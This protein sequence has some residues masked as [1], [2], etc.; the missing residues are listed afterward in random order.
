[1][2]DFFKY[3]LATISGII[4]TFIILFF[5]A[6][7]IMVSVLS[8][9]KDEVS[10]I[11]ANTVLQ[12]NLN[13]PVTDRASEDITPLLMGD[14]IMPVGLTDILENID[15]AATD[16]NISGILL[17]ISSIGSGAATTTEIR[18]ALENFKASGKF[19]YAYSEVY[20]QKAYY[21]ATVADK[22][23]LNPAGMV[24]F[25]GL[26]AQLMFYKNMLEKVDVEVQ[27]IR[28][29]GNK[30]KSAVEPFIRDDMSEANR[31][32]TK[33]YITAVWDSF[34]EKISVDRNIPVATLNRYADNLT[35]LDA[36][37]ALEANLV[38]ELTYLD[39]LYDYIDE[40]CGNTPDGKIKTIS[41]HKYKSVKSEIEKPFTKDKIAVIYATGNIV[42]GKGDEKSVGSINFAKA[43]RKARLDNNI[44]SVV[45]RV[46]SPGGSIIASDVILRELRLLKEV[47][48]VVASY[49]DVAASGGYYISCFADKIVA[50]PN[51]ITGSIGVFG[52]FPNLEGLLI[53]KAGITLDH[54]GTNENA[55]FPNVFK[56]LNSFEKNELKRSVTDGYM[57]FTTLVAEGRGMEREDVDNIGQGRVWAGVDA[58]TIGLVDEFGGLTRSI[59]IAAELASLDNYRIRQLPDLKDP[60]QQILD[61]VSGNP[62]ETRLQN[63]MGPYYS[64]YNNIR[65]MNQMTGIQARLP[66]EIDIY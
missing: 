51:T 57:K 40:A 48:P 58:I 12:I 42:D 8:F 38:D 62:T 2:R 15:K 34:I 33:R 14:F 1:M 24:E 49:G 13:Y 63:I 18:N 35:G 54:V 27:V 50:M 39:Q 60:I 20:T 19:I 65:N 41:L 6:S 32:Q 11:D 30:Y 9:S 55:G 43:I 3:T 44:K 23:F 21:L 4:I 22:V 31:E 37:R 45:L 56:P 25:K 16:K 17:N 5:I 47:K 10:E 36:Q 53:N 64:Y 28:P 46:N 59:E 26:N 66:Y 29:D 52:M 61:I 7:A